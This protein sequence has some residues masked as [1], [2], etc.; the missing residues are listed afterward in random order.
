MR[1]RERQRHRQERQAPCG[2]ADAGL[3]PRNPGSWLEPER[4]RSSTTEPPRHPTLHSFNFIFHC[5]RWM[6]ILDV[7]AKHSYFPE[8]ANKSEEYYLDFFFF[9][10]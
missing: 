6:M 8:G 7:A 5:V 2:E 10:C 9:S 4:E 1:N 3:D